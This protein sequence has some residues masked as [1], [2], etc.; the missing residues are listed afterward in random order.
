MSAMPPAKQTS[1]RKAATAT[2]DGRAATG[3][4]AAPVAVTAANALVRRRG[5]MLRSSNGVQDDGDHSD[6]ENDSRNPDRLD[7]VCLS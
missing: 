2:H 6:T 3:C 7:D 1:R 5:V 4:H